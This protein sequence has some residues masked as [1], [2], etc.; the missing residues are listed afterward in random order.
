MTNYWY[1]RLAE[2]LALHGIRASDLCRTTALAEATVSHWLSGYRVPAL[3]SALTCAEHLGWSL[4]LLVGPVPLDAPTWGLS[5][6]EPR[7]STSWGIALATVRDSLTMRVLADRVGLD[8]SGIHRWINAGVEPR[9]LGAACIAEALDLDL[10]A[11]A[12]G[13]VVPC[14]RYL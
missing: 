2:A 11:M 14:G 6:V 1:A 13:R 9:L 7:V 3:P 10:H 5:D 4:D 12:L 8:K